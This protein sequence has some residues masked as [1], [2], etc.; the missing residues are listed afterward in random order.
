MF[1]SGSLRALDYAG[2]R[3]GAVD[4]IG[5]GIVD[6]GVV[7][8][9]E[10]DFLV[11]GQCFFKRAHAGFSSNDERRHHVRKNDDTSRI[12]IIGS[13][14]LDFV[15]KEIPINFIVE[16]GFGFAFRPATR[17]ESA[18][19][20]AAVLRFTFHD[21]LFAFRAAD[22]GAPSRQRSLADNRG[23][24]GQRVGRRRRAARRHFRERTPP[25][26][27]Q[28]FAGQPAQGA[29]RFS[30][31]TTGSGFSLD[32]VPNIGPNGHV[33]H[34]LRVGCRKLLGV[35]GRAAQQQIGADDSPWRPQERGRPG[36]HARPS[37]PTARAMSA[38]SLTM[39]SAP[40]SRNSPAIASASAKRSRVNLALVPVL[41]DAGARPRENPR[42]VSGS[43]PIF[44]RY[45]VSTSG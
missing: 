16:R 35:V 13:R 25:D 40:A 33:I 39:K 41:G 21:S 10:K 20:S 17:G 30:M 2:D 43:V 8:G 12:G 4:L 1:P 29:G 45:P 26:R 36:R 23:N 44:A 42:E 6:R 18:G 28:R 5:L 22:R 31:P 15:F 11:G 24:R 32:R 3:A 27:R 19:E 9:R 14:R 37:A 34:R 38:R 7:L